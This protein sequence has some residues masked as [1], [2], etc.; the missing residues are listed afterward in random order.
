MAAKLNL[1]ELNLDEG[2]E[3]RE[4]VL[5]T[6]C[7]AR[8]WRDGDLGLFWLLCRTNYSRDIWLGANWVITGQQPQTTQLICCDG[9]VK[10]Q[11]S[12]CAC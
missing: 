1:A 2:Q 5:W 12:C 4:N 10:V 8:W 6:S 3:Y 11:N 9:L 7:E